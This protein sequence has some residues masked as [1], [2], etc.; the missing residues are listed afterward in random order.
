MP[1]GDELDRRILKMAAPAIVNYLIL[2]FTQAVDLF[3]QPPANPGL[4]RFFSPRHL[5]RH[6]RQV[7]AR[8]PQ[9]NSTDLPKRNFLLANPPAQ[10][11]RARSSCKPSKPLRFDV[12]EGGSSTRAASV[13]E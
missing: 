10:M 12:N 9:P 6:V 11:T 5:Y 8:L 3:D 13:P 4:A 2:P 7:F 1:C